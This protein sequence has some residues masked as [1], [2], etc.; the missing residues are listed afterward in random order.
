MLTNTTEMLCNMSCEICCN[1][2]ESYEDYAVYCMMIIYGTDNSQ[3]TLHAQR[4][5]NEMTGG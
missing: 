2:L 3:L 1:P 5:T 4:G